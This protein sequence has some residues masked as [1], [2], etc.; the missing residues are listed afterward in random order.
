MSAGEKTRL[1]DNIAGFLAQVTR[2]DIVEKNLAHFH[3][4]DEEYGS[5]LE[6]AVAKLRAG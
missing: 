3:A 2:D 5:R 4:A 1:I 6:A